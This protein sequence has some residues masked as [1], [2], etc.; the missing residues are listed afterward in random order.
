MP[1]PRLRRHWRL[2][3]SAVGATIVHG[4]QRKLPGAV[5]CC[6]MLCLPA[7]HLAVL[8]PL[9]LHVISFVIGVGV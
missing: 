6:A 9:T 3:R 4:R 1:A 2:Y 8:A 7:G 5:A